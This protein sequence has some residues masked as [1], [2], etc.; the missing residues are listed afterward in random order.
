[1]WVIEYDIANHDSQNGSP[2]RLITSILDRELAS[3]TE[4]AAV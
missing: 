4:L 3:A 1:V 2:I